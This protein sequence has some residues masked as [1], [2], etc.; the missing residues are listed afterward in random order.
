[1]NLTGQS[2]C[3]KPML[4]VLNH[5]L[6]SISAGVCFSLGASALLVSCDPKT[7]SGSAG[8][9]PRFGSI[10]EVLSN[11]KAFE[12]IRGERDYGRLPLHYPYHIVRMNKKCSLVSGSSMIIEEVGKVGRFGEAFFGTGH[13]LNEAKTKEFWILK[14]G[15]TGVAWYE[16]LEILNQKENTNVYPAKLKDASTAVFQFSAD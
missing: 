3:D 10:S 5:R 4:V 2:K 7:P 16:S 9:P 6:T 8:P 13:Q 11:K 12:E 1:M 15:T 14:S